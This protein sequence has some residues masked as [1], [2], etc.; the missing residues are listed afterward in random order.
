MSTPTQ[1][2]IRGAFASDLIVEVLAVHLQAVQASRGLPEDVD[3][4]FSDQPLMAIAFATAAVSTARAIYSHYRPHF[5]LS[6][7]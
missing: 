5:F 4:L 1:V 7:G 6:K 2:P 3:G